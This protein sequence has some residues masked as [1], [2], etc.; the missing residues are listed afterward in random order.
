VNRA[1]S[2]M[3]IHII[4]IA[5]LAMIA[6]CSCRVLGS[7]KEI[8]SDDKVIV[9]DHTRAMGLSNVHASPRHDISVNRKVYPNVRGI[10]PYYLSLP[11]I[12]SILFV[13]DYDDYARS[14]HI[15]NI[16]NGKSSDIDVGRTGFSG[17]IGGS[18][19]PG[20]PFSCYIESYTSDEVVLAVAG[21]GGRR[22]YKIDLN[23]KTVEA[24]DFIESDREGNV[25]TIRE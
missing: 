12:N 21:A 4:S 6:M 23:H 7:R 18:R 15:V 13:T 5:L 19:R 1:E 3:K 25:S 16:V 9:Y 20:D 14:F 22:N 11:R 8:Y 24:G 2:N 10:A 17:L